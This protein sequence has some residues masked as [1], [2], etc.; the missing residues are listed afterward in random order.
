MV[1]FREVL[2]FILVRQRLHRER[3]QGGQWIPAAWPGPL[4]HRLIVRR[5]APIMPFDG[6]V[7]STLHCHIAALPSHVSA[8]SK[9]SLCA[10]ASVFMQD[11]FLDKIY[12]AVKGNAAWLGEGFG[13]NLPTAIVEHI[14]ATGEL[15]VVAKWARAR[16]RVQ[17]LQSTIQGAVTLPTVR[18]MFAPEFDF[19]TRACGV[20]VGPSGITTEKAYVAACGK[21]RLASAILAEHVQHMCERGHLHFPGFYDRADFMATP[22]S[23]FIA[24]VELVLGKKKTSS[25]ERREF[26]RGLRAH[27]LAD[28]MFLKEFVRLGGTEA[29]DVGDPY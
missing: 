2:D 16:A 25:H 6:Y 28:R 23:G 22:F 18:E 20:E 29:C 10:A 17:A 26:V 19:I 14:N 27:A 24:G 11:V 4:M 15:P 9:I 13:E 21:G 5:V 8:S 3:C 7:N 12:A 1:G